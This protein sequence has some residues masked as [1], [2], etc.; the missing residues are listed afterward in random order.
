LR[1]FDALVAWRDEEGE[2]RERGGGSG[3]RVPEEEEVKPDISL[4][5]F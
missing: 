2:E 4:A 3:L 1:G 5:L